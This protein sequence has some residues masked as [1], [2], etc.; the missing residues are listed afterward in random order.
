MERSGSLGSE[1]LE[2]RLSC[3]TASWP[4]MPAL[5]TTKSRVPVGE[6]AMACLKRASWEDQ[7]ITSVWR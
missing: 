7:D 5:A 3:Q 1:A 4:L 2:S 6:V